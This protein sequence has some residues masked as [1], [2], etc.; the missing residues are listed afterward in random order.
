M[1]TAFIRIEFKPFIQKKTLNNSKFCLEIVPEISCIQNLDKL[2]WKQKDDLI[3]YTIPMTHKVVLQK[4]ETILDDSDS[5]V[6]VYHSCVDLLLPSSNT[7]LG[8][9]GSGDVPKIISD[10]Y[11]LKKCFENSTSKEH[12]RCSTDGRKHS[13]LV[14][15]IFDDTT[16]TL[17]QLEGIKKKETKINTTKDAVEAKSNKRKKFLNDDL[18]DKSLDKITNTEDL[19]PVCSDATRSRSVVRDTVKAKNAYKHESTRW[20]TLSPICSVNAGETA[21]VDKMVA[22]KSITCKIHESS[23]DLVP[24]GTVASRSDFSHGNLALSTIVDVNR[25]KSPRKLRVLCRTPPEMR[26]VEYMRFIE[27]EILPLKMWLNDIIRKCTALG[28]E[29]KKQPSKQNMAVSTSGIPA[30][31]ASNE[32]TKSNRVVYSIVFD[33]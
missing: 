28:I 16:K 18:Y 24:M 2:I 23:R 10:T 15:P 19:Y 14:I 20:L 13:D 25:Q 6:K 8:G 9:S 27:S 7:M 30:I 17:L 12:N 31:T 22:S 4:R 1:E 33:G 29:F 5:T 32:T 21:L 11:V 26:V 3:E